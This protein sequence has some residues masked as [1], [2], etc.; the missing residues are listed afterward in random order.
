MLRVKMF[1]FAKPLEMYVVEG[2]KVKPFKKKKM[3]PTV[4]DIGE[5]KRKALP[6]QC[7]H[8]E[9]VVRQAFGRDVL[10]LLCWIVGCKMPLRWNDRKSKWVDDNMYH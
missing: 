6:G 1:P 3:L 2:D 10:V 8:L 4:D 7:T 9:W 5:Q